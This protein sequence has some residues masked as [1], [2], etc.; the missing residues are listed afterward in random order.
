MK[1]IVKDEGYQKI[2][3]LRF[4]ILFVGVLG[5]PSGQPINLL[6]EYVTRSL[7]QRRDHQDI[8]SSGDLED[9]GRHS[10]LLFVPLNPYLLVCPTK[11]PVGY[12]TVCIKDGLR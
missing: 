7:G 2:R 10:V 6:S 8:T 9:V 11:S 5:S 3:L 12:F 4:V 1:N